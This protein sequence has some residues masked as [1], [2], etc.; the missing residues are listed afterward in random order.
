MNIVFHAYWF[1]HMNLFICFASHFYRQANQQQ[2]YL[3]DSV[4]ADI[5]STKVQ[6][7]NRTVFEGNLELVFCMMLVYC[8]WFPSYCFSLCF[9]T[10]SPPSL[11]LSYAS[12]GIFYCL[13]Y[14]VSVNFFAF[15]GTD[16]AAAS[17]TVAIG[18]DGFTHLF[19]GFLVVEQGA[20][21]ADDEVVVGAHKVDGAALEGLGALGGVAHHQHRLAKA[22]GFLLDAARVG[23]DNGALLH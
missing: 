1:K 18:V 10:L 16:D 6:L 9:L 12:H 22:G 2:T 3:I 14:F 21:L 17:L 11:H 23:E 20:D 8:L 13:F 5:P 7:V 4:I 15:Q 19:V